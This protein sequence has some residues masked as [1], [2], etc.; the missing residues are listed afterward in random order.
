M[1][2]NPLSSPLHFLHK[3]GTVTVYS[4]CVCV[5]MHACECLSVCKSI[6][7]HL[8]IVSAYNLCVCMHVCVCVLGGGEACADFLCENRSSI[9]VP[10]SLHVLEPFGCRGNW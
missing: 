2:V 10:L 6:F 5:C 9:I 3:R 4:H 7:L 1:A 8:K